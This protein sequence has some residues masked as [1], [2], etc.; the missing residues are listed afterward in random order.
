MADPHWLTGTAP[1]R[2]VILAELARELALRRNQYA[3]RVAEGQKAEADAQIDAMQS[4][5]DWIA[6]TMAA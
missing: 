2:K 1:S 6:R 4:A 5:Y 3:G